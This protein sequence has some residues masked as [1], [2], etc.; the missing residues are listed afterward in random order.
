MSDQ[1]DLIYQ[2]TDKPPVWN[3]VLSAVQWFIFTLASSLVVPVVIGKAL[4]LSPIETA[5]F[6]Q[7]T[8]L[9]VGVASFLQVMFGHRYPIIEGPAGM[10]WGIFLIL[11]QLAPTLGKTPLE[12][13]QSLE[14]GLIFAGIV[15]VIL[16]LTGLISKIQK[17]FTPVITG[18]Y[19]IILA[20]SM[21]GSFIQGM[22]GIGYQD[23]H[24]KWPIAIISITL[25]GLVIF[26][27]SRNGV[28]FRSFSILIG[29]ITG[30]LIYA[31][32]GLANQPTYNGELLSLPSLFAFGP[33]IFDFG[34]VLTSLITGFILI[35]NLITSISVMGVAAKV[36]PTKT[37][38][39][40]GGIF[41]GIAHILSGVGSTVGLVPLSIAAGVVN[42]TGNAARIS[43]ILST[44]MVM[45][46]GFIPSIGFFFAALPA[47][48]GYAVLF[49]TFAQLL[50]FGLKDYAK[51]PMDNH[52]VTVIGLS[53][54][55][56]IGVMFIP[57]EALSSLHPVFSYLLG[58]GLILGV[59]FSLFLEHV[60]FRKKH[61]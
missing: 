36:K 15:F 33:P 51:I 2:L 24:I 42:I 32:L 61:D 49:T 30:W 39:N 31:V 9:F 25:V 1:K 21:S 48:V 35:S 4:G 5:N 44:F 11:I 17:I 23:D 54:M 40:R 43:F 34:V 26:L 37:T 52:N 12:I 29:I 53:L 22:L 10:W 60:I 38:Y 7:R 3:S 19:M 16:G 20:I 56:G 8:F 46:L 6:I 50:G 27:S 58:N 18:T 28:F 57:A 41:T 59:V 47:P 14:L 55:A 13:G 45:L